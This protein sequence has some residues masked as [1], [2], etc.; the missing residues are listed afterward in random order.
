M[1][2]WLITITSI[3][4]TLTSPV[5]SGTL[6]AVGRIFAVG[7]YNYYSINP[8]NSVSETV[9]NNININVKQ[10]FDIEYDCL[11]GKMYGVGQDNIGIPKLQ[12]INPNNGND[13]GEPVTLNEPHEALE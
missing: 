3:L 12:E 8:D 9:T 5:F 10:Y 11:T 6:F 1:S 13:I 7:V 4:L 2:N